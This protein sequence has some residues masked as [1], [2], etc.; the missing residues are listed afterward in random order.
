MRISKSLII[1]V[2]CIIFI[3][4]IIFNVG[5]LVLEQKGKYFSSNYAASYPSLQKIYYDAIYNDKHGGFV[6][7]E[8]LYS[9]IGGAL[10]RGKSP[11]F[12]NP[13]VPPF[14]TYLIGLS[15]VVFNN[16]HIIMVIFA[17]LSLFMMF[18]VGRQIYPSKLIALIPPLL[19][20]LE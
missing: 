1:K 18:M 4:I 8:F 6:P 10:M 2:I 9:C 11:I 16:Q 20:S 19:L 13:E 14:G 3:G 5:N 7:D 12:L 15:T 17:A